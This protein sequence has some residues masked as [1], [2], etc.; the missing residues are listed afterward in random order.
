[1]MKTR[2]SAKRALVICAHDD[3]EVIGAGGTIR[4][5]TDSGVEVST[6][7]FATGN[8]GYQRLTEKDTIVQRRIG[9]R[10]RAQRILG[11]TR[12]FAHEWHDFSNLDT[13]VVYREVMRAVRA[14]KPEIVFTHVQADYLA[15]R[16][17]AQL[18]PEAVWQAGWLCS[19]DLGEPW[20]VQ[21]LY[22]FPI[23][24]LVGKPSHVVDITDTLSVKLKA[25]KAYASQLE[26]VSGILDQIEAKAR[27][28]GSLIGVHYGEAFIR[29]QAIPV[30]VTDPAQ[31]LISAM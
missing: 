28:Y 20:Q 5:L 7:I 17:L 8:E 18:V 13:E 19:L 14:V 2:N 21:R 27:A 22:H 16:T 24:E 3:D 31:M 23:L 30:A 12:C 29:S 11:T 15:H 25:M 10:A 6:V 1:M 9:E 4:K 26:V